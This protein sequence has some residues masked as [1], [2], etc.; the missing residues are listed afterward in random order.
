M[1]N[2][3]DLFFS[4]PTVIWFYSKIVLIQ[5]NLFP[6]VFNNSIPF[7][8]SIMNSFNIYFNL[9]QFWFIIFE[10][11]KFQLITKKIRLVKKNHSI[12][13][14]LEIQY[15]CSLPQFIIKTER[16]GHLIYKMYHE[17]LNLCLIG[18]FF[19]KLFRIL[20]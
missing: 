19:Q 18:F 6:S 15:F 4:F 12:I 8:L 1:R 10:S 20:T 14:K 3:S 9:I 2:L 5:L 17:L 7:K 13:K 11:N 16:N